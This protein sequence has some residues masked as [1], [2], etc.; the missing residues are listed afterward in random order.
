MG[1][2]SNSISFDTRRS[3]SISFEDEAMIMKKFVL[4]ISMLCVMWPMFAC[5]QMVY[6]NTNGGRYYH[7]DPRCDAISE[8]YWNSM[9]E[10]SEKNALEIGL[11]GPCERCFEEESASTGEDLPT[12]FEDA[13]SS[14]VQLLFG[15]SR[16]DI[17]NDL[18]L[19]NDG[20]IV[21]AGSTASSDGT[22]ADRTKTERS[23]W[24]ALVDL[25]GNTY[26]NFCSRHGSSDYMESPVVH[27]D[28]T[29]TVLLNSHGHEYD[30]MELIR[31]DMD[32]KVVSRKTLVKVSGEKQGLAPEWSGVFSGGYVIAT[33]DM[34]KR[35]EFEPIYRYSD[36]ARYQPVYYWFDFDGNLLFE[37]QSLWQDSVAHVSQNHVIEAIDQTY[38]LCSLDKKGN[39]KQLAMLHDGARA[40]T[41][42]RDLISLDDGGAAACCYQLM[43]G[44]ESTFVRRWDAQ[45]NV[46][47]DYVF[48]GFRGDH[49]QMVGDKIVVGGA[50]GSV[51]E[52]LILDASSG[53]LIDRR[54]TGLVQQMG[55]ALLALDH[56]SV[57]T[58]ELAGGE[59]DGFGYANWDVQISCIDISQ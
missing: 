38:W 34:A 23:G 26:W 46:V 35:I 47:F 39:H 44:K 33:Y 59:G 12:S 31:L 6:Y 20:R 17:V 4:L 7:T 58:A 2:N 30:Q 48:G 27:D 42:Y 51:E 19:T 37:T 22:L 40:T 55:R 50:T 11:I 13:N 5:A 8:K 45:G 43:G 52:L 28:N 10:I 49:L 16:Q 29:I 25:R 53:R 3:I 1:R 41:D 56:T 15:G 24:V 14:A 57:L 21:M 9:D 18:A 54:N 36:H 32:G